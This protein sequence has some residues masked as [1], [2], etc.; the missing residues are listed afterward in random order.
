MKTAIIYNEI[1][2]IKYY[3]LGG[4]LRQFN[5]IYINMCTPEKF[6]GRPEEF[7]ILCEQLLTAITDAS[8]VTLED[9]RQAIQNGAYLIEC[10]FLP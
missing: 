6:F 7:E 10:G 4:D 5:D 8:P 1:E 9:F 3:V 2:E